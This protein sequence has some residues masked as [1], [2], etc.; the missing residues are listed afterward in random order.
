MTGSLKEP[1]T[2]EGKSVREFQTTLPAQ[3][4][5][6]LLPLLRTQHVDVKAPAGAALVLGSAARHAPAVGA[7]HRRVGLVRAAGDAGRWARWAARS[8]RS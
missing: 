5:R 2:L 4:D 8:R 3:Q 7:R 6:D 1:Q